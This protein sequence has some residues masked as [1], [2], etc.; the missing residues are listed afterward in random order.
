MMGK[1]SIEMARRE[2]KSM[3][4]KGGL[5]E[6]NVSKLSAGQAA[7]MEENGQM[8]FGFGT[9]L[10]TE[11]IRNARFSCLINNHAQLFLGTEANFDYLHILCT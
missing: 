8:M 1:K 9:L 11:S 2:E 6:G 7:S 4:E 5:K 3:D 10:Q